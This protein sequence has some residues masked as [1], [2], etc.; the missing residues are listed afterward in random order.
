MFSVWKSVRPDEILGCKVLHFSSLGNFTPCLGRRMDGPIVIMSPRNSWDKFWQSLKANDINLYF[1]SILWI[2]SM[3]KL[4]QPQAALWWAI[5]Y[6]GK[7]FRQIICICNIIFLQT[8]NLR[9]RKTFESYCFINFL[10]IFFISH[11]IKR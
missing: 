8:N 2:R 6:W 1:L 10:F 11:D 4:Y 7:S 9:N 3:A 5:C